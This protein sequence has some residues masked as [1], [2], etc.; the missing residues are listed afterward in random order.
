MKFSLQSFSEK[1]VVVWNSL[2]SK[3]LER[4]KLSVR[5]YIVP[6]MSTNS[7]LWASINF[8]KDKVSKILLEVQC[9]GDSLNWEAGNFSN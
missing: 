8:V 4:N 2:I 3:V 7:D 5:G 9:Q 6:G 1:S